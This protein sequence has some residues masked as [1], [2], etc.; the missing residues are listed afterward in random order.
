MYRHGIARSPGCPR[1]ACAASETVRHVMWDCPFAGL[2]WRRAGELLRRVEG[3][4]LLDWDKVER[5]LTG[6]VRNRRTRFLLWL[7]MSL[8]KRGLWL[9]REDL[10]KYNRDWGAEGVVRRVEGDLVGRI[11][12]EM[13]KW[14]H[15]AALER[16]KGGMGLL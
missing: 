2:M 1:A 14:G 11:K 8:C 7:I 12:R 5:G 16:W 3:G 15:H 10:V 13:E 9:A 6:V 4:L